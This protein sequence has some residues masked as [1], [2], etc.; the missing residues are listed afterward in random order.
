MPAQTFLELAIWYYNI[1]G[2][3]EAQKILELSP[4]NA[5]VSYWL[6]FIWE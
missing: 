2:K 5:E 6:A 1:G 4:S 3:E